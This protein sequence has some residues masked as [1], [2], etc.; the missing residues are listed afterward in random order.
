MLTLKTTF[1]DDTRRRQIA[2]TTTFAELRELVAAT[3]GV[4]NALL[5]YVDD[6]GDH[7]TIGNDADVQVRGV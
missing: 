3:H 4:T 6:D 7:I 1:N 5:K 2:A